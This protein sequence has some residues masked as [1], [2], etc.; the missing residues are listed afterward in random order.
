MAY[1][2]YLKIVGVDGESTADGLA[3]YMEIFSFSF[4]ASNPT[5]IGPGSSGSG[6]GRVAVSSFNV[7]KRTEKAS[8]LLFQSC[9]QGQHF[10]KADVVLRKATGKD[11]K[12]QTFLKYA[13]EE[14]FID[15]IQSS[16]SSGGDDS[17]TESLSFTSGKCE[18]E[19]YSQDDKGTM[20]KVGQAAWDLR[21]VV[22]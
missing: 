11:G 6:A 2:S 16:G 7:M 19:Y 9:C 4:G 13:F 21:K 8:A 1:D 22:A 20:K 3:G 15:G 14:V 18:I 17:P 10:A 12:Q 5:S